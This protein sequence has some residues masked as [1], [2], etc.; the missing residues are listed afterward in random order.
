MKGKNVPGRGQYVQR[1]YCQM[2]RKAGGQMMEGLVGHDEEFRFY[3]GYKG[4]PTE[5]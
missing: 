5:L 3:F 2:S 4:N 1:P